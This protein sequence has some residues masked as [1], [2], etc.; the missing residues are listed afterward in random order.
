MKNLNKK[1]KLNYCEE[2]MPRIKSEFNKENILNFCKSKI[3]FYGGKIFL[4]LL[5]LSLSYVFIY[6]LINMVITSV[7]DMH[8][9]MDITVRLI[10]NIIFFENYKIAF[11]ILNYRTAFFN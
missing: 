2:K 7:L 11:S 9:Y 8:D 6:P 1:A 4:Y 3:S 5:L 10:P